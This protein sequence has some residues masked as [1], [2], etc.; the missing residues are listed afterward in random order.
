MGNFDV[1]KTEFV[2]LRDK[3]FDTNLLKQKK[4]LVQEMRPKGSHGIFSKINISL[5]VIMKFFFSGKKYF[6][7]HFKNYVKTFQNKLMK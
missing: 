7:N 5:R 2:E 3:I 1:I 4:N 6:K